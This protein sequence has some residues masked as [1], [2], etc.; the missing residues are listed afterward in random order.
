[1]RRMLLA[2]LCAAPLAAGVPVE[3]EVQ[4]P[5]LQETPVVETVYFTSMGCTLE[6]CVDP[7]HCH[8]C[9]ADC[10]DP[11]HYHSCPVGCTD[12]AHP[13]AGQCWAAPQA[14]P[15]FR[16]SMG[17]ALEDCSDPAHCHYCP[18]DCVDPTHYHSCPMGCADPTHPHWNQCWE[19]GD[20]TAYASGA[21]GVGCPWDQGSHHG[22]GYGRARGGRQGHHGWSRY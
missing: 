19:T 21:D 18:A 12:P 22:C 7:A 1:M 16:A 2:L 17:C 9:P 10:V 14:E 8:Y 20:E 5:A 13:C 15:G 4:Q 3:G 6:D 11:T